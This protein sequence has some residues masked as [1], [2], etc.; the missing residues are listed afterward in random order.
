MAVFN[1]N[2]VM[3]DNKLNDEPFAEGY[4]KVLKTIDI[5]KANETGL[6]LLLPVVLI[7]ALPFYLVWK[8]TMS[9]KEMLDAGSWLN[10][11]KW[12]LIFIAGIAAHELVHGITWAIF[13]KKGFRSI[14]FGVMWKMLTPYCHCKEPLKIKHYLTGAITPFI[15]V[16]L[17]PAIYAIVTG[18][19]GWLFFGIFYTIGAIGDFLIINLLRKEK[20]TDYALDH[21]SEAG[22][23][24]YKKRIQPLIT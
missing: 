9:L 21:P 14:R 23:Y 12:T 22:C 17:I 15:F 5:V 8:D 3:E 2:I 6:K 7:Y 18:S 4:E 19:T 1:L 24:V 10:F 20:M 13:A 11:L 16:G